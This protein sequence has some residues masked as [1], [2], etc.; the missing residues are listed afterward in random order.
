MSEPGQRS[1][2]PG[3]A[4]R[5]PGR[6]ASPGAAEP[7]A[8]RRRA[9][10][11]GALGAGVAGAAAGGAAAGYA[12]PGLPA[13][14]PRTRPRRSPR[15]T[16]RL[17]AVPF[18]GPHQA[19]ILP[20]PQRQ[21]AVV[22][23]NVTADGRAEL[24]DLLRTLT[25]RARFLTA[26]GVP[27]PVGIGA[28]PSDSGVLGPTV[29]PDGLTVTVGVGASL[30]DDRFGL[31]GRL[32]AGLTAMRTFPERRPGPG[33][34]RRRPE[35]AA[36]RGPHRHGAARAARHRPAHPRRHAGALAHRRVLPARPA[37][38]ARPAQPARASWTASPTPTSRTRARDEQPDLGP[39]GR[40]RAGL[41][42]GRQLPGR[43]A[44][45]DAG[46]VLGP[47]RHHRAGEHDRPPPRHR[48]ARS[49][50]TSEFADPGLRRSTPAAT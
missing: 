20:A 15:Q 49:T 24:T 29:V 39:A 23:F 37:R 35:P 43:P 14:P 19:G 21:T 48:R 11:R 31:A 27:P 34:V 46:R 41:D 32:P 25:D 6:R 28:P 4:R 30:F 8:P 42:R 40:Q 38:P 47:G 22:S 44:D 5:A 9:F 10:L 3:R 1:A 16:G 7:A 50:R 12:L 45:P 33:A 18:H 17:P 13:R 2:R 26:G 36:L